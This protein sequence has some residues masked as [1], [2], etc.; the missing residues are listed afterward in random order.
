VLEIPLHCKPP[1]SRMRFLSF[2]IAFRFHQKTQ[3]HLFLITP[4]E[5]GLRHDNKSTSRA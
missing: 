1:L 2:V 5:H 4:I 3:S